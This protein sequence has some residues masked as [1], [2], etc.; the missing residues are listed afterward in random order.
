[1]NKL[2]LMEKLISLNMNDGCPFMCHLSEFHTTGDQ[3]AS[4]SIMFDDEVQALFILS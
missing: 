3:P 4:M 2:D 1:M